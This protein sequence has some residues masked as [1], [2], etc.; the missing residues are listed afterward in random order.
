MLKPNLVG[1]LLWGIAMKC[2]N[3]RP[4]PQALGTLQTKLLA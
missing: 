1:K 3:A 2:M 4:A